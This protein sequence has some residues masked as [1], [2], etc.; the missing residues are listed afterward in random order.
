MAATFAQG[1]E[2]TFGDLKFVCNPSDNI[3]LVS[4]AIIN[5]IKFGS[6]HFAKNAVG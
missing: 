3:R 6:L 1:Q 2:V 5:C 4:D